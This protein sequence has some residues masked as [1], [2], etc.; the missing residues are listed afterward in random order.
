[1]RY[2]LLLSPLLLTGCLAFAAGAAGGAAATSGDDGLVEHYISTES[3]P[4]SIKSAMRSGRV[5][6]GMKESEARITVQA[7]GRHKDA[8]DHVESL[9]DG[10]KR[11]Y[12]TNTHFGPATVITVGPE[13]R[14]ERAETKRQEN[15]DI[16]ESSP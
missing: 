8:P 6:Q 11:I 9:P 16:P 13:G 1:M 14:V 5:I 2:L 12:Y 4:D 7:M 3:P 15:V 10:R